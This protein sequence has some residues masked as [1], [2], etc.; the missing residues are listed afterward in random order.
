MF[1]KGK[2]QNVNFV[3]LNLFTNK[4]IL[5]GLLAAAIVAILIPTISFAAEVMDAEGESLPEKVEN[6]ITE[7]IAEAPVAAPAAPAEG[8]EN[9]LCFTPEGASATFQFGPA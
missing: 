2:H 4:K 9:Y 6:A 1:N 7:I 3:I 8:M 5:L